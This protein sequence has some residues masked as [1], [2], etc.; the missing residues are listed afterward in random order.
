M[1]RRLIVMATF[2]VCS[3]LSWFALS[4][5]LPKVIAQDSQVKPSS[6][7][8]VAVDGSV[9]PFPPTPSASVVGLT[10]NDSIHQRRQEPKRLSPDAPNVL[11][12]L[13]DDVG[14]GTPSTYGGEINTPTLSRVAKM[15][16]SYNRFHSTA[17]CSP[18]RA[19]LLTGRNHTHVCNGQITELSN[20]FDGFSG[21]I[22][23]SAATVAEVLRHY[24]YNTAAFGKWHNTPATEITTKG[25]FDRWP[26]GYGFE[27]FY[28]FLAGESGHY[29]PRLIKNTTEV[30]PPKTREQGYHLSEDLADNAVTWLR[31]QQTFAADKPFFMYWSSGASHGPHHVTKE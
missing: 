7:T 3:L 11:V 13:I 15:G 20:D 6:S 28:G 8:R 5:H 9:L 31:E 30:R 19:A 1:K 27:Y 17:M 2:W 24:G 16:V 25:P 10:L 12:I 18:T 21:A 26:T 4:G 22:P 29:E 23:K 14:P